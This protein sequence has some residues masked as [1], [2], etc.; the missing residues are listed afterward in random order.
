MSYKRFDGKTDN[1]FIVKSD[2][3]LYAP[4]KIK[5]SDILEIWEFASSVN[6]KESTPGDLSNMD[7]RQAIAGLTKVVSE[8]KR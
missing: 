3:I 1:E 2:N 8:M 7:V 5:L 6:M 4:Y